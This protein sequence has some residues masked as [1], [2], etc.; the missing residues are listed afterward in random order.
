MGSSPALEV[1]TVAE[2]VEI[3]SS[4]W[5]TQRVEEEEETAELRREGRRRAGSIRNPYPNP[6]LDCYG[7]R[8]ERVLWM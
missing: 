1:V 5:S 4:W 3:M 2:A 7:T 8:E 6:A